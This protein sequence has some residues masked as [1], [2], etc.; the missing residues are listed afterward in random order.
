M[1][2]TSAGRVFV[3]GIRID[4]PSVVAQQRE[5][6]I[7]P[8]VRTLTPAVRWHLDDVAG[9]NVLGVEHIEGRHPDYGPGSADLHIVVGVDH[10]RFVPGSLDSPVSRAKM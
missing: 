7:N 8:H 9:W 6:T 10:R 1:L 3:T 4:R 5:V 2:H